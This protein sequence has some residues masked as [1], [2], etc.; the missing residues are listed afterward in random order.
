MD[1]K[2]VSTMTSPRS[3]LL[4]LCN[5]VT[6]LAQLKALD[7]PLLTHSFAHNQKI[8]IDQS[9]H[10]NLSFTYI[11]TPTYIMKYFRV[12]ELSIM[13]IFALASCVE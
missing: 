5:S 6:C 2:K 10:P 11:H 9:L 4:P 8:R 7:A 12:K 13:Y 3:G 1:L